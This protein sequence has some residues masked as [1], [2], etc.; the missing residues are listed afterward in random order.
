MLSDPQRLGIFVVTLTSR[1]CTVCHSGK[2]SNHKVVVPTALSPCQRPPLVFGTDDHRRW[3]NSRCTLFGQMTDLI[4]F[5]EHFDKPWRTFRVV[6]VPVSWLQDQPVP[7]RRQPT[8]RCPAENTTRADRHA[9]PAPTH[10]LEFRAT[11]VNLFILPRVLRSPF[12]RRHVEHFFA[13]SCAAASTRRVTE[14]GPDNQTFCRRI[15]QNTGTG[16]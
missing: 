14:T 1:P 5:K 13:Y 15:F 12:R 9:T 16:Q 7:L 10:P 8:V 6:C 3:A 2:Q 11:A 4:Q